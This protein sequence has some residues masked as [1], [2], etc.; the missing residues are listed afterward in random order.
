MRTCA[1]SSRRGPR[2]GRARR[3]PFGTAARWPGRFRVTR[4]WDETTRG[5]TGLAGNRGSPAERLLRRRRGL[6][7]PLFLPC[8][9]GPC[10][11]RR[12]VREAGRV[13]WRQP[14]L[15]TSPGAGLTLSLTHAGWGTR[16]AKAPQTAGVRRSP[17]PHPSTR[18]SSTSGDSRAVRHRHPPSPNPRPPTRAGRVRSPQKPRS[19]GPY[20][21][22]PP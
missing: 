3:R 9:A 15:S 18:G 7:P 14:Q 16:I 21:S 2:T 1:V 12:N 22:R 5:R 4:W 11:W 8:C 10:H 19:G 17:C 20:P 13:R 6:A